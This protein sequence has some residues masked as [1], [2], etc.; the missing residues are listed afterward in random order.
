MASKQ[1]NS[2][3]WGNSSSSSVLI[4]ILTSSLMDHISRIRLISQ[5]NTEICKENSMEDEIAVKTPQPYCTN[6]KPKKKK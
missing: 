4:T 3:I 5:Q 6:K 2:F 1:E